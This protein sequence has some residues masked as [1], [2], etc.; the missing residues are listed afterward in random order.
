MNFRIEVTSGGEGGCC[1]EKEVNESFESISNAVF[2]N[3]DGG[4][5]SVQLLLIFTLD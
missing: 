4:Y 2:L 5:L 3:P 1:D